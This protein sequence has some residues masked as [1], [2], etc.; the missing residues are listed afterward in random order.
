MSALTLRTVRAGLLV[1]GLLSSG[2][3]LASD[4]GCTVLLCLAN[5]SSNGGPLGIAECV[6]PIRKLFRDLARG[7][8]FPSCNLAGDPFGPGTGSYAKQVMDPYDPCPA[9]TRALVNSAPLASGQKDSRGRLQLTSSPAISYGDPCSGGGNCDGGSPG[10]RACV[11]TQLGVVTQGSGDSYTDILVFDRIVWQ[12]PQ[13]P[14]AI[15]VYIDNKL[16]Q[17]VRW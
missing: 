1:A 5:P 17:R 6:P 11:G 16:F 3:A 12:Q 13:T 4:Y 2:V 8:S 15:D 14:R 7:H 9:G 10:P